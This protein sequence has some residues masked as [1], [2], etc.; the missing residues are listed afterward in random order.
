MYILMNNIREDLPRIVKDFFYNLKNLLDTELYFYGSI[1]RPDY[2]H[3][4]SDIDVAIFT[5][6][7]YSIMNQL[8]YIIHA[9]K[10][11]FKKVV[12]KLEGKIVYGFKIKCDPELL[13]GAECEIAIYNNDFKDHILTDINK[14]NI[15]P[16][17]TLM[18]LYVLKIFY[19]NIPLM[20]RDTYARIKRFIF[21]KYLNKKN[22]EFLLI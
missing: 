19:Y 3:G 7:E 17:L 9:K 21:N 18:I 22:S 12:W 16:L 15:V 4:K 1:N 20:S 14:A 10:E 13:N 2:I 5:D 11:D 8:Q 6:N